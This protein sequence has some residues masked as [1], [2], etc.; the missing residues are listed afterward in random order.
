MRNQTIIQCAEYY[1]QLH[2]T[3][4]QHARSK[5]L[6]NGK[7]T[8]FPLFLF[9]ISR[10]PQISI[11][12]PPKPSPSHRFN[13]LLSSNSTNTPYKPHTV[14]SKQPTFPSP[15]TN[16]LNSP[17]P[18]NFPKFPDNHKNSQNICEPICLASFKPEFLDI[19]K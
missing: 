11:K 7:S 4:K 6:N 2:Q 3:S 9:R 15:I 10:S 1:E 14:P 12:T 8:F 5:S 19:K 18:L 17:K 16:P 13:I